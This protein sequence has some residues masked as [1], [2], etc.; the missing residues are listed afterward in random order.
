MTHS[1]P[2]GM[3]II[4]GHS[5]CRSSTVDAKCER[6]AT[7]RECSGGRGSDDTR[8]YGVGSGDVGKELPRGWSRKSVS[9]SGGPARCIPRNWFIGCT[10]SEIPSGLPW[11]YVV[12]STIGFIIIISQRGVCKS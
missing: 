3:V 11:L 5:K 1:R 4:C 8:G 6:G 9:L 2:A 7:T 12:P 10:Y